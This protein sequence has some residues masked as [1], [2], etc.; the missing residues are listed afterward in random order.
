M[1]YRS[2]IK[3]FLI[4]VILILIVDIILLILIDPYR[5]FN[6]IKKN[7]NLYSTDLKMSTYGILNNAPYDSIILGTSMLH[8]IDPLYAN[9]NLGGQFINISSSDGSLTYRSQ[10]LEYALS[11]KE[12]KH[13]IFSLDGFRLSE[14]KFQK[15]KNFN[16]LIGFRYLKYLPCNVIS[17]SSFKDINNLVEWPKSYENYF[18]SV[19]SAQRK[20]TLKQM[21]SDIN[22]PNDDYDITKISKAYDQIIFDKYL[23][24]LINQY[25]ETNFHLIFPP[26]SRMKYAVLKQ[27][28]NNF[29]LYKRRIDMIVT[30]LEKYS[31]AKVYGFDDLPF[32]DDLSNYMD[33]IHHHPKFNYL[34]IDLIK[35]KQSIISL[36]N[37]E[38]YL[39]L[40]ENLAYSL[41]L[42]ETLFDLNRMVEE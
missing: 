5:T 32:L 26:Y 19:L 20:K 34:Q 12:L 40:I 10:V 7:H 24:R 21:I 3:S 4:S 17:C 15:G 1:K 18:G 37:L 6:L 9:S 35:N 29:D 42:E 33:G 13:V 23:L 39:S 11:K 38:T 16:N 28:E 8:N 30:Q 27:K 22:F 14:D 25:P 36:N 31:N 41:D 2:Y